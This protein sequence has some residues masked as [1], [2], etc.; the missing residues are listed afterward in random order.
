MTTTLVVTDLDGTILRRDGT[1]SARTHAAIGRALANSVPVVICTAR[2]PR[3]AVPI[4]RALGIAGGFAICSSGSSIFDLDADHLAVRHL[5]PTE[6]AVALVAQLRERIP[7]VAFSAERDLVI[8]REPHYCSTMLPVV[9]ALVEDAAIFVR[10][11]VTRLN[12]RHATLEDAEL[13]AAIAPI[14]DALGLTHS[15]SSA[16][17]VEVNPPGIDKGSGTAWVAERFGASPQTTIA[18]GDDRP[19]IPMLRWSGLGVA[20]DDAH[21]EVQAVADEI[22]A[23]HDADGVADVLERLFA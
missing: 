11:P 21:P 13:E 18:F 10:G 22:C 4:A 12:A 1:A 6:A 23:A 8:Y 7:G 3:S 9:P 16:G 5:V 14:A 15:L 19:D 17:F 20:V 2:A